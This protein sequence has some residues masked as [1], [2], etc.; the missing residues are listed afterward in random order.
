MPC[1][2]CR[3]KVCIMCFIKS[4]RTHECSDIEEVSDNLCGLV[5]TDAEKVTNFFTKTGELLP[6]IEKRKNDVIKHLADV[7]DE[8]N[9]AADKLIAAIQR[10][11]AKLI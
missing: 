8:V 9:T 3:N 10:D 4:H 11:R 5:V 7:E 1:P 2:M 6:R